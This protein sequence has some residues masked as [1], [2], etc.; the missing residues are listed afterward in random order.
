MA[1]ETHRRKG[2]SLAGLGL[3]ILGLFAL[4]FGAM[5]AG[6]LGPLLAVVGGLAVLGGTAAVWGADSR[7]GGR[8]ILRRPS[9]PVPPNVVILRRWPGPG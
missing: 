4:L 6:R 2:V 5:L 8:N 1:A 7:R 3:A 9:P